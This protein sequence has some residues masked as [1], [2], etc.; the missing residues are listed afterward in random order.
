VKD[1]SEYLF[2]PTFLAVFIIFISGCAS[3]HVRYLTDQKEDNEGYPKFYLQTSFLILKKKAARPEKE[4]GSPVSGVIDDLK[5]DSDKDVLESVVDDVTALSVPAEHRDH[6][7]TIVPQT[8]WLGLVRTL[9]SVGYWDNTRLVH[10]IGSNVE[11]NRIK[12]IQALGAGISA[13]ATLGVG[14]LDL[15]EEQESKNLELPVI[16]QFNPSELNTDYQALKPPNNKWWYKYRLEKAAVPGISTEAEAYFRKHD[17]TG[18]FNSSQTFP[19]SECQEITLTITFSETPPPSEMGG[20]S[21][22]LTVANPMSV[23]LYRLPEKGN[24]ITHSVCGADILTETS[25]SSNTWEIIGEL[26]KQ[27][28]SVYSARNKSKSTGTLK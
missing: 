18:W 19:L 27:A 20:V 24:V 21:Y 23:T 13:V 16:L 14:L 2:G 6:L 8:K 12:V 17:D 7:Y 10:K 26:M 5:V 9:L 15:T 28:K 1:L 22:S 4:A 11:D 25:S 3:P